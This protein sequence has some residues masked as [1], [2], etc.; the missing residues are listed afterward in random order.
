[1]EMT[2]KVNSLLLRHVV[3]TQPQTQAIELAGR[4]YSVASI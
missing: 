4:V 3:G 2:R 1:M